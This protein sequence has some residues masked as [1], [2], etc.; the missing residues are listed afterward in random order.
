MIPIHHHFPLFHKKRKADFQSMFLSVSLYLKIS[1]HNSISFDTNL[2]YILY[3]WFLSSTIW[4]GIAS[5]AKMCWNSNEPI[6]FTLSVNIFCDSNSKSFRLD[7]QKIKGRFFS[8]TISWGQKKVISVFLNAPK[9][10]Y[11]TLLK[12][13]STNVPRYFVV[14]PVFVYELQNHMIRF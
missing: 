11:R 8:F 13:Q 10:V 6:N 5:H 9:S 12:I 7:S 2:N 3:Q 14:R 1:N 4:T